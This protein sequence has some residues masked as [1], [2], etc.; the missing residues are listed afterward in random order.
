[1]GKPRRTYAPSP[2]VDAV[3]CS[4]L[5]RRVIGRRPSVVLWKPSKALPWWYG[6]W[7]DGCPF[8]G[9]QERTLD[10]LQLHPS[11]VERI[12]VRRE[13]PSAPDEPFMLTVGQW[14]PVYQ[15]LCPALGAGKEPGTVNVIGPNGK[16]R[17]VRADGWAHDP[18]T[19]PH[20]MAGLHAW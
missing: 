4:Y 5:H 16:R 1:V 10:A 8:T 7:E 11:T 6:T 18:S 2:T 13:V 12:E 20:Q 19:R 9:E 17:D 3:G 14:K 15:F